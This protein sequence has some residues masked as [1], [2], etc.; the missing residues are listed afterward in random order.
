MDNGNPELTQIVLCINKINVYFQQDG[1]WIVGIPELSSG[2]CFVDCIINLIKKG[3]KAK[4][5]NRQMNQISNT[6]LS[7]YNCNL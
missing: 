2:Q 3:G 7:T 6:P 4:M 5:N 1:Y